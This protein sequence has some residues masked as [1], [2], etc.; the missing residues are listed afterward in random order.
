MHA[1]GSLRGVSEEDPWGSA[2][3]ASGM[4]ARRQ[5]ELMVQSWL[6]QQQVDQEV[7]DA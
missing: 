1:I 2:G 7:V 5:P 3:A 6:S 4:L